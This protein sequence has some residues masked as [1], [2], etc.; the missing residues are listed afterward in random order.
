MYKK[1]LAPSNPSA[2][3]L[4]SSTLFFTPVTCRPPA[5]DCFADAFSPP[6]STLYDVPLALSTHH[7]DSSSRAGLNREEQRDERGSDPWVGW[8]WE[9]GH[10]EG[11]C[12]RR[13]GQS[14]RERVCSWRI[15]T[16]G[17]ISLGML[18]L[19][20][21][22]VSKLSA[23]TQGCFSSTLSVFGRACAFGQ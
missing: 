16:I 23:H 2:N 1:P 21:P 10:C 11:S 22:A 12:G 18:H 9:G 7:E 5:H 14:S 20:P 6:Y 3:S 15:R 19:C 8:C 4:H 13:R 17:K